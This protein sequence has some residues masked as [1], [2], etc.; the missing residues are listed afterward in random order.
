MGLTR[1][2]SQGVHYG[3]VP[4]ILSPEQPAPPVPVVAST[5][6]IGLISTVLLLAALLE[7]ARRRRRQRERSGSR[8]TAKDLQPLL[9][10]QTPTQ[11]MEENRWCPG[12]W[13][14]PGTAPSPKSDTHLAEEALQESE[15]RFRSVFFSAI[16]AIVLAD[17]DGCIISWN[18]GAATMFGYREDE[19]LGCPLTLLMPERYRQRHLQGLARLRATGIAPLLG[20]TLEFHG[21]RKDGMEFPLELSLATWRVGARAFY[22]GIMRDITERKRAEERLGKINDCFLHFTTEFDQNIARVTALCGELLGA[23]GACY[24]RLDRGVLHERAQWGF[25]ASAVRQGTPEGQA[26]EQVIRRGGDRAVVRQVAEPQTDNGSEPQGP[27]WQS[28]IGVAVK[29]GQ[30]AVGCLCVRSVKPL[31]PS[32]ADERLM[33]ILASAIGLEEERKLTQGTLRERERQL[34]QINEE[35]ERLARDLHDGIIQSVYAIGLSL[36]ECRRCLLPKDPEKALVRLD[37]AITDLNAVIR[38][39]RSYLPGLTLKTGAVPDLE[40]G[41]ASLLRTLNRAPSPRFRSEI[42]PQ[43]AAQVTPDQGYH[44]LQIVREALSNSLRHAYATTGTVSLRLGC[45]CIRLEVRDDGVGFDA[46]ACQ[47]RGHGLHNIQTRA[48]KL[49]AQVE[50]AS[51]PGAGTR[52]SVE[53]PVGGWHGAP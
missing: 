29:L 2:D 36:T 8:D 38:E 44:L 18:Q 33:G 10:H 12:W 42:D 53:V 52:I 15:L 6:S 48:R 20:R 5:V 30:Q 27:T 45:D 28:W 21:L 37:G 35:R 13:N 1:S 43:A 32:E 26:I 22:S 24:V 16:D 19:I 50:I 9:A 39:V 51:A 46:E 31:A 47:Q 14:L 4:E 25:P 49:G 17:G 7:M 23:S 34:R 40:T 3:Q 11:A 41:L